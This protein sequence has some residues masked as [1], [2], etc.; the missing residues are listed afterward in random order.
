M[1]E[2]ITRMYVVPTGFLALA[3]SPAGT[4]SPQSK[5]DVKKIF[6]GHGIPFPEGASVEYD[7]ATSQLMVRNTAPNLDLVEAFVDGRNLREIEGL[8]VA[9]YPAAA[10]AGLLT[11]DLDIPTEGRRLRFHGPQA[12]AE[13][14]LSYVSWDR[15]I[16]YALLLML[17]GAALF[18]AWGR[19]RPVLGTL[20]VMLVLA[21]GVGLIT[22]EWQALANAALVGWLGA[23]ALTVV[24]KLVKA[25]EAGVVEGRRA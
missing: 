5:R 10:K 16:V 23:L 3:G 4:G 1:T 20:L 9:F 8:D 15:Q 25:F 18:L 14:T 12:P 13:L 21:L 6:E 17:A 2:M 24:W 7:P 22:E 11:L 19:R